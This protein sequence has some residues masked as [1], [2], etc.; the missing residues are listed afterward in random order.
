LSLFTSENNVGIVIPMTGGR[1]STAGMRERDQFGFWENEVAQRFGAGFATTSPASGFAAS[2]E[3][4]SVGA[5]RISMV[6]SSPA[7]VARTERDISRCPMDAFTVGLLLEGSAVIAQRGREARFGQG[8]LILADCRAPYRIRFDVPIRQ[9]VLTLD[10]DRLRARLPDAE[11]HAA[12]CVDGRI[13]PG[14]VAAAYLQALGEHTSCLG[15]AEEALGECALD[16]VSLAFSG[17]VISP[18]PARGGD[19]RPL[20]GR[21]KAFIEAHLTD[22][23]LTPDFVA[24]RHGV[25]RRYLYGLFEAERETIS[26]YIWQRRLAHCREALLAQRGHERGVS[27]I[28]FQWGFNDASHFSRAFRRAFGMSPREFQ[29]QHARRE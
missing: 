11:R 8:D 9:L 20:L 5:V 13:G 4:R 26:R 17:G 10:H 7:L 25:S 19:E 2:L 24:H 16:L 12:T 29:Q 27:E 21:I 23:Q 15:N 1:F 14:R 6:T 18:G 28:A 22:P 3:T